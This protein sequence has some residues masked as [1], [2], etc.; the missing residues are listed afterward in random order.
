LDP[1]LKRKVEAAEVIGALVNHNRRAVFLSGD[2]GLP[3]EYHGQLSGVPWPLASD[4]EW[5][6]LAGMRHKSV[7]ER[8][9]S[10]PDKG[11]FDYFII[12]DY[13]EYE[14][15]P[16]LR[17]FLRERFPIRAQTKEYLIFDLMRPGRASAARAAG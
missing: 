9:A 1:S 17:S 12:L 8:F 13:S 10:L 16:A 11:A 2:Y 4:L 6:D 3:L 14:Q 15:Q 5:E 7:E